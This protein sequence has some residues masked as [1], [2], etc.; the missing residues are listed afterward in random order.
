MNG[1]PKSLSGCVRFIERFSPVTLPCVFVVPVWGI[2]P[3]VE[4]SRFCICT[5]YNFWVTN[6]APLTPLDIQAALAA[7]GRAIDPDQAQRLAEEI[8]A[9]GGMVE[10]ALAALAADE[11]SL[12]LSLLLAYRAAL[13][14]TAEPVLRVRRLR[15]K[16]QD[17]DARAEPLWREAAEDAGRAAGRRLRGEPSLAETFARRAA[18]AEAL[19]AEL[20]AEAFALRLQAGRIEAEQARRHDLMEV[21]TGFAA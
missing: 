4:F 18:A 2:S 7:S 5:G 15:R 10:A 9:R 20:E 3:T 14:E 1:L 8:R 17:L 19:A 13:A 11:S 6:P 12:L 21:L 16:A